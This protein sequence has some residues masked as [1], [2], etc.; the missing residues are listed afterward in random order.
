MTLRLGT[1]ASR[2]AR[3]QA[4]WVAA[5]LTELGQTVE[6]IPIRT[7]GDRKQ[8]G[9]IGEIG[10]QGVF[11]KEIQQSLLENQID[12]AVHSLKDLATEPVKGLALAAVPERGPWADC[13][14]IREAPSLDKLPKG[15]IVGTGSP[16]RSTQLLHLRPDLKIENIRGNVE[17]RLAK[18]DAGDYDAIALATAG[19]V[20]LGLED[21][22]TER[23]DCGQLLPAV[24]QGALGIEVRSDDRLTLKI[25]SQL[26]DQNT[27]AAVI[28]ERSMM[29]TLK[30]GCLAPVAAWGRIET[31]GLLTLTGRVM[32]LD[33]K[34]RLEAIGSDAPENA[35]ELG[36]H[37]A[38]KL[39]SQGAAPIIAEA[40]KLEG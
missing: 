35:V 37:L 25:L 11:T 38:H 29:R 32:S 15:V 14:V 33:G 18:L 1:R 17:T 3:W 19:L 4:D 40:R 5:R 31:L 13:L 30:G 9:P 23:L 20:R 36:Q 22:I 27:Y 7:E 16:R 39:L 28:A 24:G 34:T 2:L 10:T 12:L 26:N 21:R 6:L 8:Q